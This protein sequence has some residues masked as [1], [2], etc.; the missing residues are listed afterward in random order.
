MN[1]NGQRTLSVA[2]GN[3]IESVT[4][5]NGI[6]EGPKQFTYFINLPLEECC[7]RLFAQIG[8]DYTGNYVD[9]YKNAQMIELN[10]L[11]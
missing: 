9:F 6:E 11:L 8:K 3:S 7:K 2:E 5:K 10:T 4:I 1:K